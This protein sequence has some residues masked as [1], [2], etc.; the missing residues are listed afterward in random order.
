MNISK[1]S[2][3]TRTHATEV[4]NELMKL[5]DTP[6]TNLREMFEL[7]FSLHKPAADGTSLSQRAH[8]LLEEVV[9]GCET[10]AEAYTAITRRMVSF[11]YPHIADTLLRHMARRYGIPSKAMGVSSFYAGYIDD[12]ANAAVKCWVTSK[13][14]NRNEEVIEYTRAFPIPQNLADNLRNVS[15]APTPL[16]NIAGEIYSNYSI[17][18]MIG[19]SFDDMTAVTC[20]SN[21]LEAKCR[22]AVL[23]AAI[24]RF[25]S[26]GANEVSTKDITKVCAMAEKSR[27][28][29]GGRFFT[30]S[31]ITHSLSLE[32]SIF[33]MA[34]R[35]H[36]GERFDTSVSDQ[37][38]IKWLH[39]LANNPTLHDLF[40][41]ETLISTD[42]QMALSAFLNEHAA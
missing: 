25:L 28:G 30:Y 8:D 33:D 40:S 19:R 12:A 4:L 38:A 27:M 20:A 18:E 17:K 35:K 29:L 10:C 39:A 41:K 42:A 7:A 22:S 37:L 21:A 9:M 15:L 14:P 1:T 2:M 13:R 31:K 32:R 11:S 23:A 26:S 34:V 16:A 24:W 3:Y 5:K 6:T 36:M